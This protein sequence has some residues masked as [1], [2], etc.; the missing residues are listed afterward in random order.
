MPTRRSVCEKIVKNYGRG[1][2][3]GRIW[4]ILPRRIFRRSESL[5]KECILPKRFCF[6]FVL[7]LLAVS[8]I[9]L[10]QTIQRLTRQS[11]GGAGIGFLLTDGTVMFQGNSE[12]SWYKLTPD[13]TGNYV[14]G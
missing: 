8:T 12:S 11:P 3:A 1:R 9:S 13:N 4:G 6:V 10:A 7:L 5:A 14:N 2:S